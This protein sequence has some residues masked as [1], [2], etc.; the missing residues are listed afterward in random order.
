MDRNEIIDHSSWPLGTGSGNASSCSLET[1]DSRTRLSK[2]FFC[3][4]LMN[5]Y[6]TLKWMA[7]LKK[8]KWQESIWQWFWMVIWLGLIPFIRRKYENQTSEIFRF[9]SDYRDRARRISPW[10]GHS[11]FRLWGAFAE[12]QTSF[13][14]AEREGR[15]LGYIEGPVVPPPSTWSVLYRRNKDYSHQPG[16]Y[17]SVTCLSIAK[18]A[19]ALGVGKDY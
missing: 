17:I 5:Y 19:Q 15:I 10:R 6:L 2:L 14:V 18:E 9:R 13:L 1:G 4:V 3:R 16:G 7:L 12:I 8:K 11:S